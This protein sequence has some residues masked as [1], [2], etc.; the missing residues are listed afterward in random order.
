MISPFYAQPNMGGV[1]LA[2]T[3]NIAVWLVAMWIMALGLF[4]IA[5]QKQVYF[6]RLW[7]YFFLFPCI[8]I[9][10]SFFADVYQPITWFFRQLYILG[11]GLFL[12]SL[13]QFQARQFVI[14]RILFIIVIGA[15]LQSILGCIQ[16][17]A[18]ELLSLWFPPNFDHVPRGMF[19]QINVQASFLVTALIIN[20]YTISRPAFN[21]SSY[22]IKVFIVFSFA[23]TLYVVVA[24]GSRIGL[25]SLLLAVPIMLWSRKKQLRSK[26]KWLVV[27]FFASS[28]SLILGQSGM[29]QTFDKTQQLIE[30]SYSDARVTMYSIGIELV[31]K[32]PIHGYGIGS[33]LLAWNQQASKFI[34]HHPDA[35]L[36]EYVTHPHNELLF[37]M[38]EGGLL[39]LFG[40]I[41]VIA[42]IGRAIY[43]CGMQRGGAYAAMLLPISLH[44]Q[45]EL[46]FYISSLHWFL[47]LFLIYLVLRHST[48]RRRVNL[49]ASAR[50]VLQGIAMTLVFGGT[51]FMYNCSRAQ[52]D[53][54]NFLYSDN[55]QK[56]YLQIALNNLYFRPEAE[57]AAMQSML[58]ASIETDDRDKVIT[59]EKWANNYVKS[60]PEL[61][62]YGDLINA[63]KYLRPDEKGCDVMAQTMKMYAQNNI[64]KDAFHNKCE[65]VII[66]GK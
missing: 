39:A 42:G 43:L 56:P 58:Y 32:E 40:I 2:L 3:Y 26:K 15:L 22:F 57:K 49:S 33:F 24:S 16:I 28:I 27:L 48:V 60:T 44:T 52:T 47:W 46:P 38:I 1:G 8:V 37:W 36:P 35:S 53:L 41:I 25:L 45:V 51:Y 13:F 64:L 5:V 19:Q 65:G 6:T 54:F 29:F 23:I 62:I 20:L 14:D 55:K 11:G 12:F 63:S 21:A 61:T 66:K 7:G 31:E 17:I 59:F 9:V 34:K 4:F 50:L 30:H 10:N 18:P